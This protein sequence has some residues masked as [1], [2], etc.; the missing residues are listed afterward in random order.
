MDVAWSFPHSSL[1]GIWSGAR[2]AESVGFGPMMLRPSLE[3]RKP[4]MNLSEQN[5][6]ATRMPPDLRRGLPGAVGR[7]GREA[8]LGALLDHHP[9]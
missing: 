5:V 9:R 2:S 6:N 1:S 7:A 8:A 4:K 3:A